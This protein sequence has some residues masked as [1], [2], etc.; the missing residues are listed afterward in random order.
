MS[1]FI[2]TISFEV[3]PKDMFRRHVC[4]HLIFFPPHDRTCVLNNITQYVDI[5]MRL[6]ENSSAHIKGR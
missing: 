6:T 5:N 4:L 3:S 2:W 1:F